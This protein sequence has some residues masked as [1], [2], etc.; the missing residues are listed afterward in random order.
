MIFDTVTELGVTLE[1]TDDGFD[2]GVKLVQAGLV[3]V[4]GVPQEP[5]EGGEVLYD[6]S[7]A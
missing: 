1:A 5:V 7:R 4:D 6:N 3:Q 2:P